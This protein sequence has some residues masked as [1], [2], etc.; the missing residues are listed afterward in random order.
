[1]KPETQ[2]DQNAADAGR[3]GVRIMTWAAAALIV[4]GVLITFLPGSHLLHLIAGISAIACGLIVLGMAADLRRRF[5]RAR[6]AQSAGGNESL[7]HPPPGPPT[8]AQ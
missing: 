4:L 7:S 6:A 3:D 8:D 2:Q 5:R 1:M